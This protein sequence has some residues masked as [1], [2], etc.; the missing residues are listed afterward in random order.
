[1]D[2]PLATVTL[3]DGVLLSKKGQK[4]LP[5]TAPK[6]FFSQS[7]LTPFLRQPLLG[8]LLRRDR[9]NV[10]GLEGSLP[11]PYSAAGGGCL[12]RWLPTGSTSGAV[13]SAG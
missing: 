1:M 6:G 9:N 2:H 11:A 12:R 13:E 7:F 8:L 4:P 10:P 3:R 5:R